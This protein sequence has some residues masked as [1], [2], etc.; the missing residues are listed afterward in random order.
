MTE[1]T[2]LQLRF[3]TKEEFEREYNE[4][5][6]KGGVFIATSEPPPLRAKVEFDI[7]APEREEPLTLM[8]EVVHV[9]GA[10]QQVPGM[11]PGVA[12]QI[13]NYDDELDQRLKGLVSEEP[14]ETGEAGAV[15]EESE[16]L[17][18]EV[19]AG[20]EDSGEPE[21]TYQES[22]EEEEEASVQRT[23]QAFHGLDLDNLFLSVRRLPRTEKIKLAKRGPKKVLNILIQEADKQILR[24]VVQNPRLG[25]PEVLAILKNPQTSL[26]I[27]QSI[28]KNSGFMQ[29]DEVKYHL[30]TNPKTPLPMA[31]NHLKALNQKDL[32]KIAKSRHVKMQLKSNALKLLELRRGGGK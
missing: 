16:D 20:P 30:V 24:F 15:P 29:S 6:S 1:G 21:E 7:F 14:A 2:R 27:I 3:A 17:P 25:V 28:G 5:L 13:M 18:E 19:E 8:G 23:I 22:T 32:A 4:N 9:I 31:L 10:D 12:L 26:E 11:E